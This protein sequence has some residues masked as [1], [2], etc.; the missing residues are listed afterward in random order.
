MIRFKFLPLLLITFCAAGFAQAPILVASDVAASHLVSSVEPIYP[1]PAREARIQGYVILQIEVD[2]SGKVSNVRVVRGH[3]MLTSPAVASVRGWKYTPFSSDGKPVTATTWVSV[4]FGDPANHDAEDDA[5]MRFLSRYWLAIQNATNALSKNEFAGAE[6]ALNDAKA[7]LSASTG[8]RTHS[9]ENWRWA[10]L[11]GELNQK[12][13]HYSDAEQ[14]YTEALTIER[15]REDSAEAAD[16]FNALGALYFEM[17]K[18]DLSRENLTK[19][20]SVYRK[21]YKSASKNPSLQDSYGNAIA[22]DSWLLSKIAVRDQ[23]PEENARQCRVVLDFRK[24][25]GEGDP[26]I[27]ECAQTLAA[28][29]VTPK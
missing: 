11:M 22:N 9:F 27:R 29:D 28:P 1:G 19:A 6:K 5:E 20:V 2:P 12:Q 17:N 8:P 24:S 7:S 16:S 4:R 14:R 3:P 13:K 18:T 26:R 15:D 25:M 10:M 21:N 23:K